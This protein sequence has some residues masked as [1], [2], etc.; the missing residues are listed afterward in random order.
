MILCTYLEV[1]LRL[2]FFSGG[3]GN[4]SFD[5]L[6]YSSLFLSYHLAIAI[7]IDKPT[8]R[9]VPSFSPV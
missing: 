4:Y 8:E 1:F 2:I 5:I 9:K 7:A 6:F 3:G